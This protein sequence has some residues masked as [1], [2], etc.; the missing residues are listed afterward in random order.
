MNALAILTDAHDHGVKVTVE[1]DKIILEGDITPEMVATFKANKPA[2]MK[3]LAAVPATEETTAA[4]ATMAMDDS[5]NDALGVVCDDC[6]RPTVAAIVT[7]YG[8][9]Y[10]RECIFPDATH[11]KTTKAPVVTAD[12]QTELVQ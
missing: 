2:I 11:S 5:M 7:D 9:R 8:A 1:G 12:T 6:G 3:V 4:P 10:C